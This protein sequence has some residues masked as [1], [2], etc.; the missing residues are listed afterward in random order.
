MAPQEAPETHGET[1]H[2]ETP[3]EE[4]PAPPVCPD[5]NQVLPRHGRRALASCAVLSNKHSYTSAHASAHQKS[6]QCTA[7]SS[8]VHRDT[9]PKQAV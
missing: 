5:T 9:H 2:G 3:Y 8:H 7:F 4:S 6:P 1:P